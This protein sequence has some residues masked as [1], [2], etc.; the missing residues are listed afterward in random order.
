MAEDAYTSRI[1]LRPRE[2]DRKVAPE[3]RAGCAHGRVLE[4]VE[5]AVG[6]AR[7]KDAGIAPAGLG[8][9]ARLRLA[10]RVVQIALAQVLA[11]GKQI[12]HPEQGRQPVPG[13]RSVQEPERGA[14]KA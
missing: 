3:A 2:R 4:V 9:A 12:E 1:D 14:Q 13:H 6:G 8:S 10:G 5:A 11:Q 7:T